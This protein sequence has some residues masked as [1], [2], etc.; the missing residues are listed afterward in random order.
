MAGKLVE[1]PPQYVRRI[2][3]DVADGFH[4]LREA[5][6]HAGPLD[7]QTRELIMVACFATVG[8]E[9]PFKNYATHLRDMKVSKEAVQQAVFVTFGSTTTLNQVA[10]ALSWVDEVYS[11]SGA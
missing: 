8:Y 11:A 3:P 1:Q 7:A 4:S 5:V 10:L 6:T 9:M 2:S